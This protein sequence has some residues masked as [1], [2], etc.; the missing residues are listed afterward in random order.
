MVVSVSCVGYAIHSRTPSKQNAATESNISRI[1]QAA[2]ILTL[3]IG[4]DMCMV[5]VSGKLGSCKLE[6]RGMKVLRE[7]HEA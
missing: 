7:H 1:F 6:R 3:T 4:L 5:T 2:G